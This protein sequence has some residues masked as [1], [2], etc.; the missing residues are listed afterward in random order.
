MTM[1]TF[2]TLPLTVSMHNEP[3]FVGLI[4]NKYNMLICNILKIIQYEKYKLICY[5]M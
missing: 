4:N 1:A 5:V 2:N 3:V